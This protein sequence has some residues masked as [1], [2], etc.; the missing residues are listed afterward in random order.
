MLLVMEE[1]LVVREVEEIQ[2]VLVEI[3]L[4]E[5]RRKPIAVAA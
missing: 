2:E 5:Q 1:W 4:V 3:G